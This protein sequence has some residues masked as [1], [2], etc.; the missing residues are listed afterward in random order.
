[1]VCLFLEFSFVYGRR[2][3]IALWQS[4]SASPFLF[5]STFD[6]YS[7]LCLNGGIILTSVVQVFI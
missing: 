3:L 7:T 6:F 5:L 4:F 1:M 2:G